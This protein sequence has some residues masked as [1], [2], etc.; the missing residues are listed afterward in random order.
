MDKLN[1]TDQA[2][3]KRLEEA[4][5]VAETRLDRAWMGQVLAS[6]FFEFGRSGRAYDREQILAFSADRIDAVL[7][8]P[9]FQVRA[10]SRDVAQVTYQSAV[11]ID[12]TEYW[13]R[14]CS[15]W[16]R[17]ANG[18]K[19]RFHQGTPFEPDDRTGT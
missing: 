6:D 17:D 16:S 19:L 10:L 3:L 8:L 5:W 7:P 18:W 12:G 14:R 13:A 11:R 9:A 15:L 4:L 1:A 2:E